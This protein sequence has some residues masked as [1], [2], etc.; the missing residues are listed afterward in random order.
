[1]AFF[2]VFRFVLVEI[3]WVLLG[4]CYVVVGPLARNWEVDEASKEIY[5]QLVCGGALTG[6]NGGRAAPAKTKTYDNTL[7]FPGEDVVKQPQL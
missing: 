2:R 5:V 3:S 1:M 7:G 4:A 6:E